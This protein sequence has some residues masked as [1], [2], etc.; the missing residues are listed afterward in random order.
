MT[1]G[2]IFAVV[3][4]VFIE[5]TGR[6]SKRMR[7][8]LDTAALPQIDEFLRGLAAKSGWDTS[9][10]ERLTA[11]AEE[12]LAILL[13]GDDSF[14]EGAGRRLVLATRMEGHAAEMEFI[15]AVEGENVE[16]RLAYLGEM[17]PVPDEH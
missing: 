10:T 6:R 14:P 16:D 3:M 4:M 8:D 5:L 1:A 9:A 13:Q 17:S 12:T 7:V 15:S 2:A 11:A